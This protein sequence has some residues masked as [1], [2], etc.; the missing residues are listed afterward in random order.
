MVEQAFRR[1]DID[2]DGRLSR[3]KVLSACNDDDEVRS[4]LIASH[5]L[6]AKVLSACNDD[7]EVRSPLI[8]SH[9]LWV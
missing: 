8:A 7:D 9:R 4:P 3:A 1:I 2:G 6:W 5:R